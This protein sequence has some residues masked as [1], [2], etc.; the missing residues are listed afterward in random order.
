[1]RPYGGYKPATG[2]DLLG[3]EI[4]GLQDVLMK[5]L[6]EPESPPPTHGEDQQTRMDTVKTLRING[7][8]TQAMRQTDLERFGK[9]QGRHAKILP[10]TIRDQELVEAIREIGLGRVGGLPLRNLQSGQNFRGM[11]LT[12]WAGHVQHEP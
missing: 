5:P 2:D 12:P 9:G 10:E 7:G 8:T 6:D 4:G 11:Q 3:T 1:M